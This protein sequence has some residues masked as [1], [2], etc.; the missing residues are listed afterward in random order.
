MTVNQFIFARDL[1]SRGREIR[2]NKSP[3]TCPYRL[4]VHS[5]VLQSAKIYRCENV[6]ENKIKKI[7]SRENKL[8]YSI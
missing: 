2:E 7:N 1:F 8:I 5:Q 6:T 4:I 3:R